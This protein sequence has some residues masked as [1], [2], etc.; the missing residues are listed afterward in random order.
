MVHRIL[1]CLLVCC[2]PV[3]CL[4]FI[5][6]SVAGQGAD[7]VVRIDEDGEL[8]LGKPATQIVV[9]E[10]TSVTSGEADL[11]HAVFHTSPQSSSI[12]ALATGEHPRAKPFTSFRLLFYSGDRQWCIETQTPVSAVFCWHLLQAPRKS[13]QLKVGIEQGT[14][15]EILS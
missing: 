8:F 3:Y 5:S 1:V 13:E 10:A 4:P 12:S 11:L 14:A 15:A 6:N 9:P 2:L 7:S